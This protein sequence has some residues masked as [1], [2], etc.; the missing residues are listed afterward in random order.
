MEIT[1]ILSLLGG[2][3][4]FLYGMQVMSN[5]LETA[6]GNRM[7]QILEKLTSNRLKGVLVGALI[8]ALIQSSSATTVMT[9]GFV[10]SGLMTLKQAVWVIMGANIG[11]TVTGL[12]I[13]LDIGAIAPMIAFLGVAVYMFAKNEKVR[14]VS[15]I[16]AGLGILFIGMEMMS[17]SME[18]LRESQ[19]FVDFMTKVSNPLVGILVGAVFTAII[20]SSSASVGIL[21]ALAKTGA[22]PFSSSV[23]I[24][25]GQNIGTCITAVLASIGTKTNAKRTTLLHLMFNVIGTVVFTIICITTPFTDLIEQMFP[26]APAA[27]IANLHI[28][29]NI[30]TTL[31]L[32]PF[33]GLLVKAAVKLLPGSKEEEAEVQSLKYLVPFES[34]FSVGNA[35]I[36]MTQ[37]EQEVMRMTGMVREN[38]MAAFDMLLSGKNEGFDKI[39]RKEEYIDYLNTEISKYIVHAMSAEMSEKDSKGINGYY[40]ITGNLERIGDH[41]MNVAGYASALYERELTLS[42]TALSEVENM[43]GL[44]EALLVRLEEH[45]K[46]DPTEVLLFVAQKEQEIDDTN[47]LYLDLQMKRMQTGTCQAQTGLIYSELLTDFERIGDHALNIAEQYQYK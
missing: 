30:V 32:L 1:D 21:Q 17:S 27:Q 46:Y 9:V 12:L 6:V 8:T 34:K 38:T 26:G 14:H 37:L 15:S 25:F 18:P 24:L 41:A 40:L 5:G 20:Q 36:V 10:N 16:F 13:A 45:E 29:F 22:V 2:L 4:L 44:C 23:Y 19:Q 31:L 3:A 43:R 35:A 11:T 33:G 7:K 39:L 42:E 28:T 47:K